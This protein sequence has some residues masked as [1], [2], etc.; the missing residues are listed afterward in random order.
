MLI[1][2]PWRTIQKAAETMVERTEERFALKPDRIAGDVA[3]GTG[4]ML[5]RLVARGIDPHIP[6][7]DK[8][9]R[10][11]DTFSV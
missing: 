3:Y 7:W 5:A 8:S 2:L 1:K 9:K 4:E 10:K 11:D 6:V